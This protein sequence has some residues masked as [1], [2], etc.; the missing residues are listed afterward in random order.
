[1]NKSMSPIRDAVAVG[2]VAGAIL[3]SVVLV[4]G[5]NQVSDGLTMVLD[6]LTAF[7][8]GAALAGSVAGFVQWHRKMNTSDGSA[9][10]GWYDSPEQDGTQWLWTGTEWTDRTRSTPE[11]IRKIDPVS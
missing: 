8:I 6:L 5:V 2:T 1:M 11:R 10:P 7:I 3:A 4:V 9:P